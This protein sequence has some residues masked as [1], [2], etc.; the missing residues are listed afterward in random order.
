MV[1]YKTWEKKGI[2][3]VKEILNHN[4]GFMSH[5]EITPKIGETNILH[6]YSLLSSIPKDWRKIL[7]LDQNDIHVDDSSSNIDLVC[8][9]THICKFIYSKLLHLWRYGT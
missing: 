7:Q 2:V 9:K 3:Y 4:Y 1:Y 8:S 5:V 6:Y